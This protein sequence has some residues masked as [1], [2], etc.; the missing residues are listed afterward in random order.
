[1]SGLV[2]EL[3][4]RNV[5]RVGVAYLAA[6]WL[7]LQVV[8]L[9]LE[10][11]LAPPWVMQ[12]ILALFAIG[13]PIVL[14][15]SWAYEITPEGVKREADVDRSQ[16]ITTQTGRR[17]DRVIIVIL[18]LA[19]GLLLVDKYLF[20]DPAPSTRKAETASV[21]PPSPVATDEVT[22]TTHRSIAV[23]PFVSMSSDK[24][25]E[26]FADGLTEEILNSLA[27]TPDLLVA[28]RTSSFSF[29]GSAQPVPEIAAALG[30]DHV[31]EGSVRRGGD[32]LR[33]TAQLIRAAD[34][35][36]LWS[37]TFDRSPDDV[38]QV[39][40]EI[41]VHIAKALE[42]TMD[43]DALQAM[44][45]AGTTSV[46]AYE[47]WLTGLGAEQ[48]ANESGDPYDDLRSLE[49]WE[50]AVEIDPEFSRVLGRLSLFWSL[51]LTP[52]QINSGITELTRDEMRRRRDDY[53]DRAIRFERD[54]VTRKRYETGK[55]INSYDFRRAV[56]LMNEYFEARPNDY[57]NAGALLYSLSMLG[58]QD[59]LTALIRHIHANT[60]MT[61]DQ[62]NQFAL[63]L[64]LPSEKQ[65]MREIAEE[66]IDKYSNDVLLMY[67][68][69]R[70]LLHAGDVDGA[71]RLLPRLKNSDLPEVN[72]QLA[73]LRQLCADNKSAEAAPIADRIIANHPDDLTMHWLVLKI[74]GDEAR[75]EE[76]MAQEI[77]RDDPD[78]WIS[79]LS[80]EHFDPRPFPKA[81]QL[82]AGQGVEE[83]RVLDLPYRC[84]R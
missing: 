55:A 48:A 21:E 2:S 18:V 17:L 14:V 38:I 79:I 62:A 22:A 42:T 77:E 45:S 33:I 16:S 7:V 39:Q 19:V 28:A 76:A 67:Q 31:L 53:L 37:E 10:N 35:F 71:S 30:V 49:M 68:V 29:K 51:Q 46:E 34:G 83:R 43:P 11:T 44:M 84:L 54:P 63:N 47:A 41:A 3:K 80:Y 57:E 32:T 20:R 52:T 8:D 27:K 64:R 60:E 12:L 1:M 56:R 36:H 81:M 4:R 40:E 50:H 61:R 78:A 74:L 6:A 13:F 15:F 5:F 82:L 69:H 75:A 9:V 66:A 73:E 65:L 59:E 25:Q 23:L 72:T 26:W 70:L 24:D 58:R